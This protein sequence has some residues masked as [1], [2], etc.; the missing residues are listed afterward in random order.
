MSAAPGRSQASSHRSPQGEATPVSRIWAGFAG[1]WRAVLGDLGVLVLLFGG[2]VVYSFFYPLPYRQ[3]IVQQ[4]PVVVV[5]QD[6]SALSRQITRYVQAHPAVLVLEVTPDVARAHELLWRNQASGALV[7]PAGLNAT[8]LSGRAAEVALVGHGAYLLLNKAALTGLAEAVGTVSAGIEIKRL[9]ASTPS[10]RVALEQRQPLQLNPV[11]LFNVREGYGAYLVPGV[12][13]LI[14]QQ[15]LLM[16]VAM[17]MGS[18]HEAGG[19]PLEHDLG[20]FTGVWLAWTSAA[21]MHC[22]YWFGF[23]LW[24]QDYP[25]GGNLAGLAGFTLLFAGTLAGLALLIGSLFRTRERSVQLMIGLAMPIL[26]VAGL[27]WPGQALPPLL[28]GLRWL[29][30]STAGIQGFVALNQLGAHWSEIANEVWVLSALLP[31]FTVLAAWRW[32]AKAAP[33]TA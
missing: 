8:V 4:A 32:R 17:L 10:E 9:S 12:A 15:T 16:A 6:R 26:F 25:R 5:D 14:V 22:A 18:W 2:G 31:G 13:V 3:E 29:L 20:S 24:F 23:V 27:A 21:A 28:Q 11:P 7:L 19:R 33:P 30:P 1:T